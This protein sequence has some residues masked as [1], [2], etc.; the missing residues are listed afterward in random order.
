MTPVPASKSRA[1][2]T[3]FILY[4]VGMA[5]TAFLFLSMP[6]IDLSVSGLF[7]TDGQGFALGRQPPFTWLHDAVPPIL[8]LAVVAV[9][10]LALLRRLAVVKAV[11]LLLALALGPGLLAN[12]ILKDNWGRARPAQI[13]EFGGTRTFTPPLLMADQCAKNCSFVSG[14]GA[15][16]FAAIAFALL[17][18]RRRALA[19]TAA[20]G[21]GLLFGG[22]RILQGGHFLSDVL[23]AGWFVGGLSWLLYHLFFGDGW[24]VRLR[25]W[26]ATRWL[27]EHGGGAVGRWQVLA[28]AGLPLALVAVP[29]A[30]RDI[31]VWARGFSPEVH[32]AFKTITQLG[33]STGWLVGSAVLALLFAGLARWAAPGEAKQRWRDRAVTSG[34]IFVATGLAGAVNSLPKFLIGRTRPKLFFQDGAYSVE[35]FRTA[36]DYVSMPSGHTATIFGLATALAL[37][38]PRFGWPLLLSAALIGSS[39]FLINAHWLSDVIV[40]ALL[41]SGVALL[42]HRLALARGLDPHR[43]LGGWNSAINR[44]HSAEKSGK[45][46]VPGGG[47]S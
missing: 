24:P 19:L 45:S 30:D 18:A 20:I 31:A 26:L 40:G 3:G 42:V 6:Q 22:N 41:G 7:V 14:D 32:E 23:F 10:A 9:L 8:G 36:A 34:F 4:L 47:G 33:V 12:T 5:A 11:Y 38:V 2:S 46:L 37:L 15:A 35:F 1:V 25:A 28:L 43:A 29:A 16:G 44:Q 27:A 13:T 21:V 17:A 39:R